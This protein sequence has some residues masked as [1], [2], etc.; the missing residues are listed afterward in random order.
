MESEGEHIVVPR[1]TWQ[2]MEYTINE[3]T[4]EIEEKE[5]GSFTQ[6]PLR[7]AWAVTIH[8]SQG[9]TFDKVIVDAGQA[10]A[11]G[12]V[13][14]ALSRCT[15]LEGLV[16]KTRITPNALV[17]DYSVDQFVEHLPD[18]EPTK[19]MV[20]ELRHRYEFETMVE[21]IDFIPIYQDFGKLTK[22]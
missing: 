5:I 7:L 20:D 12:Q 11:H 4:Q 19:V 22:I 14:V 3:E 2:N 9:L 6:I 17:N 16:L 21:L 13:Y 1:L 15:S 10:F 8:K 18:K